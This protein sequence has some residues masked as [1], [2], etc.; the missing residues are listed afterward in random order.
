MDER[1]CDGT[2]IGGAAAS[3]LEAQ[4]VS[5]AIFLPSFFFFFLSLYLPA[6]TRRVASWPAD[7]VAGGEWM[8]RRWTQDGRQGADSRRREQGFATVCAGLDFDFG[9]EGCVCVMLDAAQSGVGD[10]YAAVLGCGARRP[11]PRVCAGT[12]RYIFAAQVS[13]TTQGV[14]WGGKA[15]NY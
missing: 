15:K 2:R 13:T 6:G 3:R 7:A 9:R 4:A 10:G 8:P 1:S 12:A 14:Q 5:R 11:G